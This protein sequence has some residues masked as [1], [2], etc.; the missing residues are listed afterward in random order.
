[1]YC[2][3]AVDNGKFSLAKQS[4]LRPPLESLDGSVLLSIQFGSEISLE[5]NQIFS[6]INISVDGSV[7]S[8]VLFA[9]R[10]IGK[11]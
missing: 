8:V 5:N 2:K 10:K 11:N 1:M 6:Y 3:I 9:A 4:E 7:K